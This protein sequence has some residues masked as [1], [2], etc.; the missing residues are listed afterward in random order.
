MR[1]GLFMIGLRL[2]LLRLRNGLFEIGLRKGLFMIGLR[3]VLLRRKG[4]RLILLRRKGLRLAL[5]DPR[6]A[7]RKV[8]LSSE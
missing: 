1:K 2:A 7:N 4:L 8:S 5:L 3:L 6:C